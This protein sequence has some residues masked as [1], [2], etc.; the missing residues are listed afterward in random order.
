MKKEKVNHNLVLEL[1]LPDNLNQVTEKTARK[2][3][4]VTNPARVKMMVIKNQKTLNR[5][6]T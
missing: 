4:E 6:K 2:N 1:L 5:S 3:Q